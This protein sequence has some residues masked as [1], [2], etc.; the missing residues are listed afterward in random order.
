MFEFTPSYS[1]EAITKHVEAVKKARVT[2]MYGDAIYN[3]ILYGGLYPERSRYPNLLKHDAEL[4]AEA[5]EVWEPFEQD[6]KNCISVISEVDSLDSDNKTYLSGVLEKGIIGC[7]YN[8]PVYRSEYMG[9]R[10]K[11]ALKLLK[12]SSNLV[13]VE[14]CRAIEN[15]LEL[16]ADY[17][18][19]FSNTE[20]QTTNV[21]VGGIVMPEGG[22]LYGTII[23]LLPTTERAMAISSW[24]LNNQESNSYNLHDPR[25]FSYFFNEDEGETFTVEKVFKE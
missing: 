18:Y 9:E 5:K 20:D 23:A 13:K 12:Q 4:T 3:A 22:I 21:S 14:I 16:A 1:F 8:N 2:L 6:V 17:A 19:E 25:L 24:L 7:F 10:L 15:F 11:F